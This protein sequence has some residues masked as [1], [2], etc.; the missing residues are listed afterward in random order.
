MKNVMMILAA[1]MMTGSLA[2]AETVVEQ[3]PKDNTTEVS[4]NPITGTK[5]TVKKHKK[6]TQGATTETETKGK[7]VVKEY[8]DGEVKKT[9]E[10]ET[11]TENK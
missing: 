3:K 11:S 9:V 8:K 7:T 4:T 1:T 5:K 2:I 10:S 6:V